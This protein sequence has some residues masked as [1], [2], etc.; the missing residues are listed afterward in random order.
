MNLSSATQLES[1]YSPANLT[2][3]A[4][5]QTVAPYTD[6]IGASVTVLATP[7]RARRSQVPLEAY[8]ATARRAG[9]IN[10][11]SVSDEEFQ[12]LLDER[13]ALLDRKLDKS[14]S[15]K[16]EIRLQYVQWSLDRIEDAK[17][18][19]HLDALE[20]WVGKYEEFLS[21][22]HQ[23]REQLAKQKHGDRK[24]TRNR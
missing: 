4:E 3:S 16:E 9:R 12:N 22:M 21:E 2:A 23:L 15:R 1:D 8:A 11:G 20:N 5:P 24:P 10:A 18:G 19:E 6:G 7:E 13:Q 14:I 17:Y